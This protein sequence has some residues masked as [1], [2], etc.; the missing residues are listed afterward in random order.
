LS[1]DDFESV[2]DI[3]LNIARHYWIRAGEFSKDSRRN[4]GA[5]PKKSRRIAGAGVE[6]L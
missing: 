2:A 4:P 6:Y 5:L 3:L 1:F